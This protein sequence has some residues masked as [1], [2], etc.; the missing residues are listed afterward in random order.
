MAHR[1]PAKWLFVFMFAMAVMH[2]ALLHAHLPWSGPGS[3]RSLHPISKQMAARRQ[4]FFSVAATHVSF[5]EQV[6]GQ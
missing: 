3:L 1:A 6:I 5:S 2:A 4:F